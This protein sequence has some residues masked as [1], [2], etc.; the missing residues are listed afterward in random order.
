MS[1]SR[2]E[3]GRKASIKGMAYERIVCGILMGRYENVSLV[4]LPHSRYDII[5]VRPTKDGEDFIRI[6]VKSADRDTI[7]FT[8]G[9]RGGQDRKY[10]YPSP[11][12]YVY[13]PRDADCIVGVKEI[14]SNRYDLYFIPTILI[15]FLG[16]R[17]ISLN[18]IQ[19]LKNDYEILEKC[20]DK[21][22]V[23]KKAK[24][25]GIIR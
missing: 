16:Q 5:L 8:G 15:E 13:T 24:T 19:G 7:N 17:S 14:A 21:T 4:E 25:L 3:K 2:E 20:K 10:I 18:K 11:K 12:E 1:S 22:F 6:Q 23:K 9:T